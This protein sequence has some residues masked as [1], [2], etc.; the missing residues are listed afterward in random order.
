MKK[1]M[2][3]LSLAMLLSAEVG[4]PAMVQ[5]A[6]A[7]SLGSIID[8]VQGK[9]NNAFKVDIQG[10]TK[11]QNSM[12][13]NLG[14]SAILLNQS[15]YGV[16][17]ALSLD[18]AVLSSQEAVLANL[19]SDRMNSDFVKASIDTPIPEKQIKDAASALLDSKDQNRITIANEKIKSSENKRVAADIYTALAARDA[20]FIIKDTSL[21]LKGGNQD[22][23]IDTIKQLL[24]AAQVA[25][26]YCD[27]QQSQN[28][29]LNRALKAYKSAQNIKAASKK[30]LLEQS[31][32]WLPQ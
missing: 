2:I 18:P 14:N 24:A 31:K 8:A 30:E 7:F 6:Q 17:E 27:A 12:L 21:A 22:Q 9:K 15:A 4:I 32:N 23:S 11:R 20:V 10:L 25:K 16:E 26:G 29:S 3:I 5:P 1:K 19:N 28:K 13:E